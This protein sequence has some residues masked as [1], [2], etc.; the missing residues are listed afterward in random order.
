MIYP[1]YNDKECLRRW[2]KYYNIKL[3]FLRFYSTVT[4]K[5]KPYILKITEIR[6]TSI[7]T[8]VLLNF[9]TTN[10]RAYQTLL[11]LVIV[12]TSSLLP[13]IIVVTVIVVRRLAVYTNHCDVYQQV[14]VAHQVDCHHGLFENHS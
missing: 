2:I 14:S 6:N 3:A 10:D 1:Y 9:T 7:I 11:F 13:A 5:R 8:V 12:A 4:L